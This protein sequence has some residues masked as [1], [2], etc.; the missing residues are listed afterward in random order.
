MKAVAALRLY[1]A[2]LELSAPKIGCPSTVTYVDLP[3]GIPCGSHY[4]ATIP[5]RQSRRGASR[6][7]CVVRAQ[8]HDSVTDAEA[9]ICSVT[10]CQQSTIASVYA[11]PGSRMPVQ[12]CMLKVHNVA[13][14]RIDRPTRRKHDL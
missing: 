8:L 1:C 12:E 6:L 5:C 3:R 11:E 9:G 7:H 2:A 4:T 13:P 10:T 14:T